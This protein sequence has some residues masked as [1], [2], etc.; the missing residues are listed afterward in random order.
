[1]CDFKDNGRRYMTA[2][3][4]AWMIGLS[5]MINSLDATADYAAQIVDPNT[6]YVIKLER[7][8]E[9]VATPLVGSNG[10]NYYR[11]GNTMLIDSASKDVSVSGYVKCLGR[12]WG[13]SS[14]G[15]PSENAFHRLFMYAPMAG[16][17]IEGRPAYQINSNLVMTVETN[18]M[19]WVNIDAAVCSNGFDG[20]IFPSGQFY[21]QFPIKLTFYINER[22]IDGQ[23]VINAMDL[24]GYVRAYTAKKT[25]PP[26]DSWPINETTV[27]LRL[28]ASQIHI[29][30]LCTTMTS[31]G[32]AETV[33]LRHGKLSS[34][35]YDSTVVEKVTYSC[36]FKSSTNI[37]LRLDYTKDDDPQKR[38]PLKSQLNHHDVIYS[39]LTMTDEATG[40]TGQSLNLEIHQLDT[41]SITS[42][43]QGQNAA[44]G[45][46]RG[47]AWLIATYD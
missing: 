39:E 23:L 1:M 17:Y 29:G 25:V 42:R 15:I 19:S 38:L 11:I 10:K 9:I 18:L 40:Q 4:Y 44:A 6:G 34:V 45:D 26:Y 30:S 7:N 35:N 14:V 13:E 21:S 28:A 37:R 24:G 2:K 27:P 20:D 22:I 5:L 43:I 32:Q 33:S 12:Q 16:V 41:I 36:K 47:S 3:N 31:T 8:S 46:Y